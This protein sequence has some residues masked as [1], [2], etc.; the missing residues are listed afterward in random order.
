VD[1]T[2]IAVDL[3]GDDATFVEAALALLPGTAAHLLHVAAPEP[4]FVGFAPGPGSVRRSVAATLRA[5][6]RALDHLVARARA[7]GHEAACHVVRAPTT[8]GILAEAERVDA[9]WIVARRRARGPALAA[10]LGSTTQTL[11]RHASR[12]VL[13]LPPRELRPASPA[14]PGPVHAPYSRPP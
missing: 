10:L 2:L 3:R 11:L 5:E 6:L 7:C 13:V 4:D 12:P 9:T 14:V 8:E 1:R